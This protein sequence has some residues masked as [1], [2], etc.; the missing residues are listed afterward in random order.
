MNI[1][2]VIKIGLLLGVFL[3]FLPWL[4]SPWEAARTCRI[5]VREGRCRK[6]IWR[7]EYYCSEGYRSKTCTVTQG[8]CGRLSGTYPK[9]LCYAFGSVCGY[10]EVGVGSCSCYFSC[11]PTPTPARVPCDCSE[12][13]INPIC[14]NGPNINEPPP[15]CD[16][17]ACGEGSAWAKY[18]RVCYKEEGRC[19][20]D[21]ETQYLGKICT[22]ADKCIP[23]ERGLRGGRCDCSYGQ[24]YKTCC[25]GGPNPQ[26]LRCIPYNYDNQW[27]PEGKALYQDRWPVEEIPLAAKQADGRPPS[28]VRLGRRKPPSA[29]GTGLAGGLDEFRHLGEKGRS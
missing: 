11:P 4:N 22:I 18:R 16:Y 21:N 26:P 3:W 12:A 13:G 27:P 7:R 25:S 24:M 6:K 5:S 10:L 9:K 29:A 20:P 19:L 15:G 14:A 2:G 17:E 8:G 23:G 1:K 28:P